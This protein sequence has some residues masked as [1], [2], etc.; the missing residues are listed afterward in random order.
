VEA[1]ATR[2]RA[3]GDQR[4]RDHAHRLLGVVRPVRERHHRRRR[5]LTPA[6][7]ALG[8]LGGVAA[9][10]PVDEVNADRSDEAGDDRRRDGGDE[11]VRYQSVELHGA[12]PSG[13]QRRADDA[14]DQR[15][16][17]R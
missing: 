9:D 12:R 3:V 17:R 8:P 14:A 11:D 7:R 2:Y 6:E 1:L 15:M 13:C 10:H 16:R 5:D 4:E